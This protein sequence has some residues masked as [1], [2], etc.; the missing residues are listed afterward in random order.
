MLCHYLAQK[1]SIEL[2]ETKERSKKSTYHLASVLTEYI[3]DQYEA[4][5][6]NRLIT[7]EFET[8]GKE[9]RAIV[10]QE[11]VAILQGTSSLNLAKTARLQ[12]NSDILS[13]LIEYLIA[14][15]LLI[16]EGFVHFRLGKYRQ[17]L[18]HVVRMAAESVRRQRAHQEF[19]TLLRCFVE[20]QEPL[21]QIVHVIVRPNG[22]YRVLDDAKSLIDNEYLEGL[23]ASV[24]NHDLD[25]EDLLISALLTIAPRQIILH[26]P[27]DWPTTNAIQTIFLDKIQFC[28]GC[29]HCDESLKA[30]NAIKAPKPTVPDHLE[31]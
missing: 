23:P 26:F 11:V 19:T 12:L 3:I 6:I 25:I 22:L 27:E 9:E 14:E 21:A 10:H 8:M 30:I 16:V 4:G 13:A 31:V 18:R 15:E 1:G 29:P 28:P 7:Q 24:V 2:G 5:L 17:S 20:L